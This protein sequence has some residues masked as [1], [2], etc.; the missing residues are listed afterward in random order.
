MCF[1]F[2]GL[3]LWLP[4]NTLV[5]APKRDQCFNFINLLTLINSQS[6]NRK[7]LAIRARKYVQI[8]SAFVLLSHINIYFV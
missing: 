5:S 2:M 8:K 3:S 6:I 7:I 4:L 1:G